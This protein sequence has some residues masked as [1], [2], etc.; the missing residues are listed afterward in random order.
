MQLGNLTFTW[1]APT[2]DFGQIRFVA[3]L[4]SGENK[5]VRLETPPVTFNSFPVSQRACG[6]SASCFRKAKLKHQSNNNN[7]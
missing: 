5:Y 1:R 4:V 2:Q 3:S 6:R 7:N